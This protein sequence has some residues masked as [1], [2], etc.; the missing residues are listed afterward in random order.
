M[1]WMVGTRERLARAV[2]GWMGPCFYVLFEVERF[3]VTKRWQATALQV[4]YGERIE[5]VKS[6][7]F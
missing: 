2:S 3:A 7:L 5:P 4:C 6:T 1:F